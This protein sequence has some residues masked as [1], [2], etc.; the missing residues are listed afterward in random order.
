MKKTIITILFLIFIA[1]SAFTV[2]AQVTY[3]PLE[4]IPGIT[5]GVA[6][7]LPTYLVAMF[8]LLIGVAAALAVIMITI[9][10]VQYM[11]TDAISG[12]SEGKEKVRQALFGLLIAIAA[13]LILYTINPSL[14]GLNLTI[15]GPPTFSVSQNPPS[16]PWWE[17]NP[18]SSLSSVVKQRVCWP[19]P[20]GVPTY[21]PYGEYSGET[22]EEAWDQCQAAAPPSGPINP[23]PAGCYSAMVIC[24]Y[25]P[26]C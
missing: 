13:W 6:V 23:P 22:C 4:A 16:T 19:S 25:G 5:A 10:G 26:E 21:T 3:V 1:F 20:G 15:S 9:G 14:T 7:N 24:T 17:Q 2:N 12:K 8:K 18:P 11:S